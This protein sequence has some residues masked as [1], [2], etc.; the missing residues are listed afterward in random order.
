MKESGTLAVDIAT[1]PTAADA[2]GD[3]ED[4]QAPSVA[5]METMKRLSKP[6]VRTDKHQVGSSGGGKEGESVH[7]GLQYEQLDKVGSNK[8]L[9]K[10]PG[11]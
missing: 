8:V 6:T 1:A 2:T 11:G 9:G 7:V 3:G 4:R 10:V 5:A